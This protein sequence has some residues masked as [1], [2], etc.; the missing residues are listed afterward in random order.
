[1]PLLW[2]FGRFCFFFEILSSVSCSTSFVTSYGELHKSC[3]EAALKLR[4]S[5]TRPTR[6]QHAPGAASKPANHQPSPGG[7]NDN[8][9]SKI[10]TEPVAAQPRAKG[11]PRDQANGQM[12]RPGRGWWCSV[13]SPP[14]PCPA[15]RRRKR[16]RGAVGRPDTTRLTSPPAVAARAPAT[17]SSLAR[18]ASLLMP[19]ATLA[20]M[21][22]SGSWWLR[23]RR[24]SQSL[25]TAHLTRFDRR[26]LSSHV[27]CRD[28]R[29][30]PLR[31]ATGSR[32]GY[33]NGGA[34]LRFCVVSGA[35][36]QVRDRWSWGDS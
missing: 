25:A 10:N 23:P 1:M 28:T 17:R 29:S 6:R 22:G 12:S 35:E 7:S 21:R 30:F 26:Y 3:V 34:L 27:P 19:R 14:V 32:G 24:R 20:T 31:G 36:D 9:N 15:L 13:I 5:R 16:R 18:R 33:R 11:L 4:K 2:W 8:S